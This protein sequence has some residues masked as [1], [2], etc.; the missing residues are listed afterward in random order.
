MDLNQLL[1]T[2]L[3]LDKKGQ[4]KHHSDQPS[5][6]PRKN[7]SFTGEEVRQTNQENQRF[8]KELSKQAEKPESKSPIP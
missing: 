6:I 7:Y 2:F 8:L 3:Q 1:K 5:V 4:Q